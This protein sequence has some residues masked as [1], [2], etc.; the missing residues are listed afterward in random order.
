MLP[1]MILLDSQNT[2]R[3]RP[4]PPRIQMSCPVNLNNVSDIPQ[5]PRGRTRMAAQA[6]PPDHTVPPWEAQ[7]V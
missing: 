5:L 4:T 3:D 1:Y 7:G 2:L 6:F